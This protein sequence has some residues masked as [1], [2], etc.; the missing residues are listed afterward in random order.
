MSEYHQIDTKARRRI[1]IS[2]TARTGQSRLNVGNHSSEG[3]DGC[4]L[5]RSGR[6]KKR[7]RCIGEKDRIKARAFIKLR[8]NPQGDMKENI[9]RKEM[10]PQSPIVLHQFI[11]IIY[12]TD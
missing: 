12:N 1:N 3:H 8:E 9:S 5:S 11:L 6:T 4:T 2:C 7:N 10:L